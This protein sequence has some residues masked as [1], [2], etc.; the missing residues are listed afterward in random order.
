MYSSV[1]LIK[2]LDVVREL[3]I[4]PSGLSAYPLAGQPITAQGG[5]YRRGDYRA[6]PPALIH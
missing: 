5:D 3:F 2:R 1:P 4:H 6:S